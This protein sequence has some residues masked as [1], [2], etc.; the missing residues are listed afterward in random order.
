MFSIII[1]TYNS[2][3]TLGKTLDSITS[4]TFKDYEIV[5]VDGKSTDGTIELVKAYEG[6]CHINFISEKDKGIYDAMNK[7]IALAKG[8]W[9][10]FLGSDDY[11]Y[12]NVVL[13]KV[14]A[15]IEQTNCDVVYGNVFVERF[16]STYAGKFDDEKMCKDNICHQS[17]FYKKQYVI[18]AGGYDISMKVNAD[19]YLNK[20]LFANKKIK[21]QFIDETIAFYSSDG[22]SN[23]HFDKVYWH[24]AEQFLLSHYKKLVNK[25]TIYQALFPLIKYE[26]SKKSLAVAF[27]ASLACKS[28]TPLALWFKHP[29]S[30]PRLFFTHKL[31]IGKKAN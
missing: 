13:E 23:S 17:I 10:Y 11:L 20:L 27:R 31:N 12:S 1:P 5:I 3:K 2:V 6:K 15:V 24:K 14:N 7:G 26:F 22:F 28:F 8:N 30:I 21:W 29:L 18:E 16:N 19:I 9:V 4:Q 25:K